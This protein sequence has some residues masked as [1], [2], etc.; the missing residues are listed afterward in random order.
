MFDDPAAKI[1]KKV[2]PE[3]SPGLPATLAPSEKPTAAVWD[4]NL[5]SRNLDDLKAKPGKTPGALRSLTLSRRGRRATTFRVIK[6]APSAPLASIT[7]N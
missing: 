3:K 1:S 7:P 6:A 5:K 4:A 2:Q